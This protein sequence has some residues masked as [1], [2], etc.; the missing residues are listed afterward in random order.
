MR[1]FILITQKFF[2]LLSFVVLASLDV[3]AHGGGCA[4]TALRPTAIGGPIITIPAYTMPQGTF[5][6][7]YGINFLNNG[8][9]DSMGKRINAVLDKSSNVP[10]LVLAP[11][12]A[13]TG[14]GPCQ[15]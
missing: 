14:N 7:G 2:L 11:F 5:S 15:Y 8:R 9:L 4:C 3:Q 13:S 6:V 1:A 10:I 12:N